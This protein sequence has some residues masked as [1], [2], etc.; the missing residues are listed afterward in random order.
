LEMYL[1][2]TLIQTVLCVRPNILNAADRSGLTAFV[3][4]DAHTHDQ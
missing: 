3:Q 4:S 2:P 1:S